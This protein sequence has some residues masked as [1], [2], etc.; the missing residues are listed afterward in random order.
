MNRIRMLGA[1]LLC[2]SLAWVR[3]GEVTNAPPAPAGSL[4]TLTVQMAGFRNDQGVA[5]VSLFRDAKGFP[6]R[7]A[8]AFRTNTTTIL[9]REA[10]VAFA[11]LPPGDYAVSVLHDENS[12]G[13]MDVNW[14]GQPREGYGVSSAKR[15]PTGAPTFAA[16]RFPL[17]P[18][19]RTLTVH[20][21]Y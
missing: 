2:A 4:A 8:L 17:A 10:V 7:A 6:D 5:Q 1:G 19:A 15:N 11:G 14:L 13:R 18:P 12:N 16:A 20:I 3:A 9:Q 21:A